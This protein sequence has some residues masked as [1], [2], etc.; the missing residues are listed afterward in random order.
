MTNC[1]H[2]LLQLQHISD[3]WSD[4]PDSDQEEIISNGSTDLDEWPED[5]DK[6]V[7]DDNTDISASPGPTERR[8]TQSIQSHFLNLTIRG[9]NHGDVGLEATKNIVRCPNNLI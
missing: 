9:F 5:S 8:K 6:M 4:S 3:N 1:T 2:K 7:L